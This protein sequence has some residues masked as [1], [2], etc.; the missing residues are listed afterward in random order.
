MSETGPSRRIAPPHNLG[1]L[2][3]KAEIDRLPS[4]AEGDARDPWLR[5]NELSAMIRL[6]ICRG[7][8]HEALR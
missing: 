1:R 3:G 6:A 5:E 4:V 7:A 8:I 2:R